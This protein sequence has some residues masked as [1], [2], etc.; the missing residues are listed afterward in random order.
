MSLGEKIQ[1]LR[2]QKGMTQD[3]LADMLNVSRQAVSKWETNESQPDIERIVE[4]GNLFNV[5]TDFLIKGGHGPVEK[6]KPA[7]TGTHRSS[8]HSFKTT[9]HI[10]GFIMN[11]PGGDADVCGLCFTSLQDPHGEVRVME[12]VVGKEGGGIRAEEVHVILTN[13]RLLFTGDEKYDGTVETLGWIF[14]GLIGGLVGEAIDEANSNKTRQVSVY[15]ENIA[16]LEVEEVTKLFNIRVKVFTVRDREGN[17]YF[18]QPGKHEADRWE[19]AIRNRLAVCKGK[20][21]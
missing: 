14:G 15:F 20:P 6:T 18:F 9:C 8:R 4:I 1:V 11:A 13:K 7:A 17:T 19:T 16:S 2:K 5:S 3:Q 21:G 10:C 12:T